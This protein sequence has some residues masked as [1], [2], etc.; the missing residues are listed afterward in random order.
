VTVRKGRQHAVALFVIALTQAGCASVTV[1]RDGKTERFWMP[2]GVN[3]IRTE[4]GPDTPV[5]V[6]TRGFGLTLTRSGAYF[7][8]VRETIVLLP[9]DGSCRVVQL[10]PLKGGDSWREWLTD[11]CG[12]RRAE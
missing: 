5:A 6:E 2:P 9:N 10:Q 1:E 8:L 4:L 12:P 11:L 3:V 7:G